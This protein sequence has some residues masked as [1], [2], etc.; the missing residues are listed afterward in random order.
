MRPDR[1]RPPVTLRGERIRLVPLRPDHGDGLVR[2]LRDPAVNEFLGTPPGRTPESVAEYV[3]LLLARQ[4]DGTDLPFA[5]EL[6]PDGPPIGVTRF[7]HIDRPNDAVEIGTWLDASLWRSPINSETKFLLL[8]HAFETEGA[9]RVVLQ[10]DLRNERS[11]RAIARLGATREGI[12]RGD[13]IAPDGYRR[14]SVIYSVLADEWPRVKRRLERFLARPWA[15]P[16]TGAPP[17]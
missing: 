4:D 15:P 13:R 1:F 12:L 5:I 16:P 2:A 8:R 9:H 11:Q 3:R 10:T 17:R 7:L 14:S 6:P